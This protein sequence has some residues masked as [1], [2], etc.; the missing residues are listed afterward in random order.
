MSESIQNIRGHSVIGVYKK[1]LRADI[2]SFKLYKAHQWQEHL[3]SR[4]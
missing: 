2:V 1:F 4:F 3:Y